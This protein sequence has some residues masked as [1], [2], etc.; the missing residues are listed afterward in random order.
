MYRSQLL[1]YLSALFSSGNPSASDF[2]KL[3]QGLGSES[4]RPHIV[5]VSSASNI[6][7]D[8]LLT[9]T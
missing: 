3:I 2:Q 5:C 1:T 4:D 8:Q 7:D 9:S 6:P